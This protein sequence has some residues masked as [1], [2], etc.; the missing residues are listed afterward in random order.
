M[1]TM[2]DSEFPSDFAD[3]F[4]TWDDEGVTAV[5][6]SPQTS[7]NTSPE[8][9]SS[10]NVQSTNATE[11]N[12][13]KYSTQQQLTT[14]IGTIHQQ[15]H[16]SIQPSII[17]HQQQ[18]R[19]QP[20]ITPYQYL[21]APAANVAHQ[22]PSTYHT[23]SNVMHTPYNFHSTNANAPAPGSTI[24]TS[25]LGGV[26]APAPIMNH[27]L[28]NRLTT[29][30]SSFAPA[31]SLPNQF[32]QT[33]AATVASAPQTTSY[34]SLLNATTLNNMPQLHPLG[35]QSSAN[36]PPHITGI[37]P[38]AAPGT[39]YVPQFIY[40]PL[41]HPTSSTMTAAPTQQPFTVTQT[42]NGRQHQQI[43]QPQL[44]YSQRQPPPQQ[45]QQQ[46]QQSQQQ[47]QQQSQQQPQQQ[48][49]QQPQQQQQQQQTFVSMQV[50]QV[51][52]HNGQQLQY[53][54]S[55]STAPAPSAL[56]PSA[57]GPIAA[58]Q[59]PTMVQSSSNAANNGQAAAQQQDTKSIP[60]F[61][62]FDAPCELRTNFL[63]TQMLH[64]IPI[65]EDSNSYHY[66]MAVNG[67]HPQLNAQNNPVLPLP[68][69]ALPP[70]SVQL[71]DA[72]AK[73]N[74]KTGKERNERE[75]KR[76]QKIT[77][78]IEILRLSMERGGWKVE[79]KSKYHTLSM[80][81]DYMKH[82][83]EVTKEKQ[84]DVD[85]AKGDLEAKE[86]QMEEAARSD[87]ESVTSSLTAST[88]DTL[89]NEFTGNDRKRS[90][91]PDHHG[92]TKKC[93]TDSSFEETSSNGSQ[94][95][96]GGG[97]G[98]PIGN[99]ISLD[100]MSSSVSEITD[101]N[102]GTSSEGADRRIDCL[103]TSSVSSTADVA[104]GN[105]AHTDVIINNN[106]PLDQVEKN[107]ETISI[108]SEFQLD[109]Q[110]VFISSNLP[111]LI[112]TTAGRVV[113]CNDFFL[114]VTG[115]SREEVST[116]T[117]FS[118]VRGDRLSNLFEMVGEALRA[119]K[120]ITKEDSTNIDIRTEDIRQSA[121][122]SSGVTTNASECSG[123]SAKRWKYAAIT[124]P[125]V[126]FPDRDRPGKINH[127]NPLYMT[128][129]LMTDENPRKQCF[130]CILTDNPGTN[131]E[132]GPVT[133]EL[134]SML[135]ATDDF[136]G[137]SSNISAAESSSDSINGVISVEESSD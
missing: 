118:I 18:Q 102:N 16:E 112:A 51:A 25:H 111:Q 114:K 72:R 74:R 60:P 17:Q 86:R 129:T 80:C 32:N 123:E 130:H 81:A 52:Q 78:L 132:I 20:M 30:P 109:Y 136:D 65:K 14:G 58:A 21:M 62:L 105:D 24:T 55:T 88:S 40:N 77:E 64:N 48:S 103:S 76:A 37:L 137:V 4:L 59:K 124:L 27:Q 91:S 8:N 82:L 87:P 6:A 57:P 70:G 84:H 19:Q 122:D 107:K 56:A 97:G 83:L 125:C 119:R 89:R 134:M 10:I 100:K 99:N 135:F 95:S 101:N 120:K 2:E 61:Y 26:P 22:N 42:S 117:V 106:T 96:V 31:A 3:S 47:P 5:E 116:M 49:Q 75:Q 39:Q 126:S 12:T 131:G 67:F 13:A 7:V 23:M 63:A 41:I 38:T 43:L 45:Q 53:T 46:Q 35:I 93:K 110:E 79:M 9:S 128:T 85:K 68:S 54:Q 29:A 127:P 11:V 33:T 73:R 15:Q 66:G 36:C 115:M 121:S 98:G 90:S 94:E 69:V 113:T 1:N 92:V 104:S 28:Q 71:V 50:P 108:E 133:P 34:Q 44:Q